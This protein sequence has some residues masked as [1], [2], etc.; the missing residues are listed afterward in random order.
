MAQLVTCS[1][2]KH[3]DL[4]WMPRTC[5]KES[6]MMAY[7]CNSGAVLESKKG[8]ISGAWWPV[9]FSYLASSRPVRDPYSKIN[10]M[11]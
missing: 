6:G 10:E 9:T 8:Q 4:N 1:L 3:E 2:G 11:A 7:T 5:V